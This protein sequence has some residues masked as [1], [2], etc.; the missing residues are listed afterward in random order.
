MNKLIVLSMMS[1]LCLLVCADDYMYVWQQDEIVFQKEVNVIDSISVQNGRFVVLNRQ[2]SILLSED[3]SAIDS[4]T[5]NYD[6]PQADILDVQF[7]ADGTATDVSPM[8]NE[9]KAINI[10]GLTAYPYSS[11]GRYAIRFDNKKSAAPYSYYKI[12]YENNSAFKQALADGHSIEAVFMMTET[13]YSASCSEAKFFSSHQAGGTGMSVLEGKFYF[14]PNV[15]QTSSSHYIKLNSSVT[16]EANVFYHVVG[17]WDK[18]EGKAYVYVNG[19]LKGKMD[20]VGNLK[21]GSAG[22]QWFGIG[23]DAKNTTSGEMAWNGD[24]RIVRIYDKPLTKND[25]S[26]LWSAYKDEQ[27][28]YPELVN[29]VQ[30]YSGLPVTRGQFY[31]FVGKGFQ[32]N[33]VV[34]MTPLTGN[35]STIVKQIKCLGQDTAQIQLPTSVES[36]VYSVQLVRGEKT[37]LLG[38]DS[39]VVVDK[40]PKVFE[41]CFHRGYWNTPGSAQNSRTSL[42]KA[43]ENNAF[44]SEIDIWL[45][46]DDSLVVN[47]DASL[48]GVTVQTSTYE[49][50]KN[51]T[52]VNGEKIPTLR[53]MLE[54]IATSSRTRLLIE[55]KKHS[56]TQRSI[57]ASRK[58]MEM[59]ESMGLKDKVEYCSF[60]LDVCQDQKTHDSE[61]IVS[62][63]N[64]DRTPQQLAPY[65]INLDYTPAKYKANPSWIPEAHALGLKAISWTLNT[66][67]DIIE[68]ANL[69]ADF[70]ATDYPLWAQKIREYYIRHQNEK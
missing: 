25:V 42:R 6:R 57:E 64:G 27:E 47:H 68:S 11:K 43:I 35:G 20:A 61:A 51:L 59:V 16:P 67:A 45:T 38:F 23:C 39:I 54:I 50:V 34:K 8:K 56:T 58:A 10:N 9:I 63:I 41:V 7:N 18:E 30:Y 14:L 40:F 32:N 55:T 44:N 33:D 21:W 49:Q 53:E 46:T 22:S 4:I 12:D 15:T 69:E 26:V 17:V 62:Y 31:E 13:P 36:G 29:D 24:V 60:S 2:N 19:E 65:G 5:F 66:R 52:L 3:V 1:C 37:Q 48:N 70:L 28:D